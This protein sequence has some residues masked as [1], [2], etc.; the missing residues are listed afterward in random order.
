MVLTNFPQ[1]EQS[2]QRTYEKYLKFFETM[3]NEDV[4]SFDVER[5]DNLVLLWL[6]PS[7]EKS[8][9]RESFKKELKFLEQ[10]L[11]FY[12]TRKNPRFAIPVLKMHYKKCVLKKKAKNANKEKYL[13]EEELGLFLDELK[14]MTNFRYY[15][16]ALSQFFLG[17][18]I[19]EACG[20]HWEDCNREKMVWK[21]E[22][23][24]SW[25]NS[26]QRGVIKPLPKNNEVR[27]QPFSQSFMDQMEGFAKVTGSSSSGLVFQKNGI[28]LR[29]NSIVRSYNLA[30]KR[31]GLGHLIGS[32]LL[33]RTA[34]TLGHNKTKDFAAAS[35]FLGHS[36]VKESNRY[37]GRE[38]WKES[39]VAALS[40]VFDKAVGDS[41]SGI[42]LKIVK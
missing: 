27:F 35:H 24:V 30:L 11:K 3:K 5:I 36:D 17:L 39:H 40:E 12:Q 20:L 26:T 21:I 7:F 1:I 8:K 10:L 13:R 34:G 15:Y 31:A 19:G 4:R 38:G 32:H 2:S 23:V 6:D 42:K 25:A 14:K 41:S 9:R 28:P 18:R 29:R 33:R 37:I 22:R 16:L